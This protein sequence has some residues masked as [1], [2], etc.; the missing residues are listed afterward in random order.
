[1]IQKRIGEINK[2]R[3]EIRKQLQ[4]SEKINL[5]EI[6][7]ELDE[8]EVEMNELEKRQSIAAGINDG[9]INVESKIIN[10]HTRTDTS[11]KVFDKD[12]VLNTKE[13]RS[14]WAKKLMNKSLTDIEQ[15]ALDIALTTTA[16]E[17]VAPSESADGI[18]NGGLFVPTSINTSLMEAISLVSPLYRDVA[19]TNVPGLLRFP[20]RKSGSGAD[21]QTEGK[22][23]K[24]GTI[25][26]GELTFGIC[27]VSETVRVSWKLEVMAVEDF[28]KYITDE[29]IEQITDKVVQGIIYGSGGDN[30]LNG[31]KKDSILKSYTGTALDAISVA[32]KSLGKKQKIGAKI[33]VSEDIIEDTY[34]TKDANGNYIYSP[35]NDMGIKSI[36]TYKVE[37]DPF[38]EAGDF[39]IGNM[40][41]YY[42]LNINEQLSVTKDTSGKKRVNDYTG[43]TVLGGAA[44]PNCF[45]FG[46]KDSE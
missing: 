11:E 30:Q 29:L 13:Y 34:F 44:Q 4:S 31:I 12:T 10:P 2:R 1:M 46:S 35:I 18:N 28:I 37:T 22:D 20:Y 14:A 32:L 16:T 39:V 27:E 42:R 26:W 6:N 23:N 7:Q 21:F 3:L 5:D 8:L 19:K 45:V 43:Y 25:E 24:D 33:Y 38:L 41:R 17:Y 15:R 40:G 9:A 36:A